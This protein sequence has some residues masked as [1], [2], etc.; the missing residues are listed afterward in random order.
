[1]IILISIELKGVY[2][3]GFNEQNGDKIH[4]NKNEMQIVLV[5]VSM[6]TLPDFVLLRATV[7]FME[8]NQ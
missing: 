8:Y 4:Q 5:L 7:K 2:I 6:S 3:N 1:M